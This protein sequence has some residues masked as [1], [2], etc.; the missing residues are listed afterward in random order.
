MINGW[1]GNILRINLSSGAITKEDSSKYK[2]FIGGMGFGY[3]IMY[4]EV[5]PGTKPF[6]EANKVI[7]AVGPLTGSGAPC[8][9]RVNITTLSTF[10]RGNLV[11]D[12]HMGGFF[13]AY[14][15]YAGYDA[16]II[17]GKAPAPVWINIQ[18][19]QVS[20]ENAAF[21]WGKGTRATTEEICRTT[22]VEACVAAI[23]PAGEN[24][25]PLSGILNSRNHSG[26]A[27]TG[28]VLGAKNLKAI[29]VIG[30][31]GVNVANR[32]TLKTLNDYMMTQLIG[33][34]NNHVV[35][36]TP[37]AW[38]EYSA[39]R[40]RWTARKGLYWKAAEGGP[41]E[42]GDIPP[43]DQNTVGFR[44]MKSVFDLGPA[45]EKYTV[46][47]GGCHSCPIRCSAQLKVPQASEYGVPTTGGN[48]CVAQTAHSSMFP[49]GPK[50]FEEKGDG[51]VIANFVA[52]NVFDDMGLWCN[53]A[54]L[55]RDFVYCYSHDVFKRVLPADEYADIPWH[56]LEAGD[57]AFIKDL[58]LRLAHRQGEISHLADGS[59]LLAQRW[60][61]G[62][63]YWADVKNKLWSPMGFP[64]HHAN[65][66]SA[67][68]GSLVNCMFNRDAM[69]HTHINY[70]GSGLPLKLQKEVAAE[71][72]GSPDA[73][74]ET[75]NY[76]PIN[77]Y[78]IKYTKW[79]ILK[80]CLHDAVTLC[81]WVWPM[82]VSPLKSRNYRG[83][84]ALEA[85]FF[86][87]VTGEATTEESLDL[88]AERIF[89]LHRAYTVKL[90]NTKDMR[91]EH[92]EICSWV[93]DKDPD[94]E[95]F[96][97]GTDKMDR[98]DMQKS[99]T[100]FYT[101]MGWDPDLG[102]PTRETLIRLDMEDVADDLASRNLLPA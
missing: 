93:F 56:L 19:D 23:G 82:T 29:S 89:T 40:S 53:Y 71:L 25:V 32:E 68:V 42:T 2:K 17:E 50:D 100:L 38:A 14:M 91:H 79:T 30:T 70:I 34:N 12:A 90:M 24:L 43:G 73:Y 85:K 94:I 99:L 1:T 102:C 48:T 88:A 69:T 87:A 76:T 28:A 5:A 60:H 47:M 61:L 83:D 95:V 16:I 8:S 46:K 97:E 9:S 96:N 84:L 31:R 66:A 35:P 65:E 27:G 77:P 3:K 86:A 75:K 64:V 57:P 55:Q 15:K 59:F 26:G 21:L 39:P 37:Q 18:D 74:D 81:N 49:H 10:T 22:N 52:L 6:D 7:F 54:Q 13:A 11:V 45:A 4:D 41:I 58:Y 44:T 72:F 33:A 67:Q 63:A 20:I 101:A 36:S 92:D 80:C 62:E 51:R 78:K 98:E